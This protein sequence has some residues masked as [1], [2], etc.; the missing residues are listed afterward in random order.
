MAVAVTKCKL[1][2]RKQLVVKMNLTQNV[3]S[4][5][6]E[7][8]K[9]LLEQAQAQIL[10]NDPTLNLITAISIDE[11]SKDKGEGTTNTIWTV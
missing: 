11:V 1:D 5:C 10:L 3:R 7:L 2:L 8:A 4:G 9:P 6:L